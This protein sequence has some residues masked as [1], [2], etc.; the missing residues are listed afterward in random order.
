MLRDHESLRMFNDTTFDEQAGQWAANLF[1][2]QLEMSS[3]STAASKSE[4]T[5]YTY[6]KSKRSKSH[7]AIAVYL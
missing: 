5:N 7:L 6:R 2:I 3:Y 1:K 4:L